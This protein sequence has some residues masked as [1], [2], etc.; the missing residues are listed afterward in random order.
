[1]SWARGLTLL[2]WQTPNSPLLWQF[3]AFLSPVLRIVLA[4]VFVNTDRED[5]R[6]ACLGELLLVPE[7][8]GPEGSAPKR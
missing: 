8:C 2:R 1:M 3:I 4:R 6:Q 5:A 7:S